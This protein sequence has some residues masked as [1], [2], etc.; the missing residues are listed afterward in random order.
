[1]GKLVADQNYQDEFVESHNSIGIGIFNWV[2]AAFVGYFL[3]CAVGLI[4]AGFKSLSFNDID[5]LFSFAQNPFSGLLVGIVA[6][7]L[8]QSSSVTTTILVGL[9]A[10]GMPVAIAVPIVMGANFGTTL[11]N[12]FVSLGFIR[13]REAFKAAISAASVHDAFNLLCLLAF[14]PLELATG[15]LEKLAKWVTEGFSDFYSLAFESVQVSGL[16]ITTHFVEAVSHGLSALL[17]IYSG[18]GVLIAGLVILIVSIHFLNQL[19]RLLLAGTI[20]HRVQA[21][22]EKRPSVSFFAGL[23][24]TVT[25]Q[26]SSTVTSL[27]VPFAGTRILNTQ[28]IYP[29]TVGA[30]VGTCI[31]ALL[32]AFVVTGHQ[33][34]AFILAFVHLFYNLAGAILFVCTPVFKRMPIA[35][36]QGIGAFASRSVVHVFTYIT[37]CFFILPLMG[38]Y[39]LFD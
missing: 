22:A 5:S 7:A 3:L 38:L 16:S 23:I 32:A 9:V 2:S 14:F 4:E 25:L 39:L 35:L 1:M 37:L 10:A 20:K 17:P 26:S 6:T 24:A 34:E 27:L 33:N 19:L 11:T 12:S 21:Q 31:T 28:Q 29:I 18:V 13:D 15:F 36:A 30:N 8:L